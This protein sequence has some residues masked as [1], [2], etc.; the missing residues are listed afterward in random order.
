[1]FLLVAT[2]LF[3]LT[4]KTLT[5][6]TF[7]CLFE[8]GLG[9]VS[10]GK[11]NF[12]IDT[13]SPVSTAKPEVVERLLTDNGSSEIEQIF[14]P[15]RFLG[16]SFPGFAVK[17]GPLEIDA[18]I[19]MDQ[20]RNC[21]VGFDYEH[22]S[23]SIWTGGVTNSDA[24]SWTCGSAPTS[25]VKILPLV[26]VAN[27]L[28]LVAKPPYSKPLL[29]DSGTDTPFVDGSMLP[30]AIPLPKRWAVQAQGLSIWNQWLVPELIIGSVKRKYQVV[31]TSISNSAP[32]YSFNLRFLSS[33]RVLADLADNRIYYL[34]D[35]P[36][37]QEAQCWQNIGLEKLGDDLKLSDNLP[38]HPGTKGAQ[39]I[40][41]A[42]VNVASLNRLIETNDAKAGPLL[43]KIESATLQKFSVTLKT[44]AGPQFLSCAN[45]HNPPDANDVKRVIAA[46]K[47]F[48]KNDSGPR[49][50]NSIG[51][52]HLEPGL[53]I[54]PYGWDLVDVPD[55]WVKVGPQD[56]K[57]VIVPAPADRTSPIG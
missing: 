30:G 44:T 51:T 57:I 17:H 28:G 19:G 55:A 8:H 52:L 54:V 36:S 56:T 1:M 46:G 48:H 12:L 53:N 9:V 32:F 2:S 25:D 5:V 20:L 18:V 38:G 4:S 3:F 33:R 11:A 39:V 15:N 50:S 47:K 16:V 6:K 13:G 22:H 10:N 49:V 37:E 24:T 27:G 26:E 35:G 21:A 14:P 23:I 45:P 34:L 42:G 7:P 43:A 29:F 41:Y 31:Q 40:D